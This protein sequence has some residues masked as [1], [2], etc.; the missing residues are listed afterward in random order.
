MLLCSIMH[1]GKYDDSHVI[2][3]SFYN[4]KVLSL[5]DISVIKKNLNNNRAY[6]VSHFERLIGDQCKCDRNVGSKR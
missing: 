6:Y 2:V 1:V 3:E 5:F 4:Y